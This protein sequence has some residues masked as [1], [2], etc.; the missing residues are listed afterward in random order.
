MSRTEASEAGPGVYWL[1][2]TA[3]TPNRAAV[4]VFVAW[5]YAASL[6]LAGTARR[7]FLWLHDLV[8]PGPLHSVRHIV[9]KQEKIALTMLSRV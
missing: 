9:S 6:S 5:R 1:P 8:D 4:D 2:H 3:F 7:R